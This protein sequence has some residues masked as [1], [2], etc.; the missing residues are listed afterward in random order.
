MLD[1]LEKKFGK[2]AIKNLIYYIL[3]AYVIGYILLLVK[4]EWYEYI[5]LYPSLVMKGQ[6]WRLFTWVCTVPQ[7]ISILLIFMFLFY[8]YIGRAL[9]EHLGSFRYTL[10]IL[11][12]WFFTTLGTMIFFWI[13]G[14]DNMTVSTNYMNLTSFLAFAVLFPEV[15]VLFF[16]IIPVKM[17]ILAWI[18]GIYLALQV[19]SGLILTFAPDD[20]VAQALEIYT[21]TGTSML[22]VTFMRQQSICLMV[23]ILISF[24]NF[25]IFFGSRLKKQAD[26]GKRNRDFQR[27]VNEGRSANTAGG[28]GGFTRSFTAGHGGSAAGAGSGKP[29]EK[30]SVYRADTSEELVHKCCV[31]GRTNITN[32]ELMFRYCSKCSGNHEYCQEHLFTHVHVK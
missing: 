3:G 31:C 15:R 32:P 21:G 4:P 25:G 12:G 29:Q 6:V 24:I 16:G 28:Q 13:T 19:I 5:C 23:T 26:A 14:I 10:Y 30:K 20:L 27:K 18:D 7:A 2:I 11:S 22:G 9:E 17:K 1:R 8:L